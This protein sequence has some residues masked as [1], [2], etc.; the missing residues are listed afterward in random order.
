MSPEMWSHAGM[1]EQT[2]GR[3]LARS[4]SLLAW[5][6]LWLIGDWLVGGWWLVWRAKLTSLCPA[7]T[8]LRSTALQIP[9][10]LRKTGSNAENRSSDIFK[11][12]SSRAVRGLQTKSLTFNKN[13]LKSCAVWSLPI[14][15][16][17]WAISPCIF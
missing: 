9:F 17:V 12:T 8:H 11:T 4:A 14:Y 1:A 6:D 5:L 7:S 3:R 16:F 10:V 13:F 2:R 15:L